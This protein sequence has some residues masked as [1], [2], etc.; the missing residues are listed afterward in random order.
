MKSKLVSRC[1]IM[2]LP[3]ILT[4]GTVLFVVLLFSSPLLFSID[5]QGTEA[6]YSLRII[7][8][9]Q[10]DL[11]DGSTGM[12]LTNVFSLRLP[13]QLPHPRLSFVP[14]ISFTSMYYRYDDILKRAVPTDVEWREL[15]ALVPML[16]FNM[17]WDFI[18]SRWGRY[19]AEAGLGFKLPLPVKTWESGTVNNSGKILPAL[20]SDAQ[21]VLPEFALQAAWPLTEKF[22]LFVRFSGYVPVY[23]AWDGKG[24][25]FTDGLTG[26]IHL[27]AYFPF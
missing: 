16:D 19:S 7:E 11:D 18:K 15:T 10:S 24:L 9:E 4:R 17:R 21:F 3:K 25:P 1:S 22:D 12:V 2:P 26:S 20:Y 14:G 6:D 27:G 8:S 5:F 13:V 23:H